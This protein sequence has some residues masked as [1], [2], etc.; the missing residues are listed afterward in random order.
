MIINI[1]RSFRII[2]RK[3]L[4]FILLV[5]QFAA[6]SKNQVFK[7]E[8]F[9]TTSGWGY[10]IVYKDKIIIKQSVIPVI[11]DSKSFATEEDAH[12]LANLV[13]E[14][15]QQNISPTVTKNELILLKIKF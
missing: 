15:L 1:E 2:L 8:T 7:T 5:L 3:N 9:Q 12:K 13:V 11:N 6:C 14:K 4:L 10:S